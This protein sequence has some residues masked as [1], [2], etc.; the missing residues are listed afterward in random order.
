[1]ST[2]TAEIGGGYD[3]IIDLP[4]N[5]PC[6]SE[7][8]A[9]TKIISLLFCSVALVIVSCTLIATTVD[10]TD[11][12]GQNS[13]DEPQTEDPG[14]STI[15]RDPGDNATRSLPSISGDRVFWWEYTEGPG[16]DNNRFDLAVYNLTTG[17]K[18]K[19]KENV[20]NPQRVE[21]SGNY[22]V[23]VDYCMDTPVTDCK[24]VPGLTLLNLT[25]NEEKAFTDTI[26]TGD[27]WA[28]GVIGEPPGISGDYVVWHGIDRDSNS[29][30]IYLYNIA[31]DSVT[32]ITHYSD[33]SPVSG[34][35]KISGERV[36][37][38]EKSDPADADNL[39]YD[40]HSYDI[41][42]NTSSEL[43]HYG[44]YRPQ[45][46][47]MSND[48]IIWGTMQGDEYA[49][50]GH[51]ASSGRETVL[52]SSSDPLLGCSISGGSIVTERLSLNLSS[53]EYMTEIYLDN[54]SAR[55]TTLMTG[56]ADLYWT[57][58][59]ESTVVWESYPDIAHYNTTIVRPAPRVFYDLMPQITLNIESV[60]SGATVSLDNKVLGQT[61]F[62]KTLS[63][64]G[65]Y[66]L[67]LSLEGYPPYN[68][69]ID[70]QESMTVN[71][72]CDEHQIWSLTTIPAETSLFPFF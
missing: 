2:G 46:L 17:R 39:I 42:S 45:F 41:S 54:M 58:M 48:V 33:S 64:K 63:E 72:T 34:C 15:P 1:M 7:G 35:P 12:I 18:F 30:N 26:P 49:L 70:V 3:Y 71:V 22:A 60:P 28:H 56:P 40:L 68:Q 53:G 47:R 52:Q 14:Y 55:G 37:W 23:W 25:S 66:E 69:T 11:I 61:P 67:G 57:D 31:T 21:A 19:L 5:L 6:P 13:S 51:N 9:M 59:D 50:Y 43:T 27:T 32:Q 29:S 62:I 4:S 38:W 8:F 16:S 44:I 20:F 65:S 10:A 36:I 24:A